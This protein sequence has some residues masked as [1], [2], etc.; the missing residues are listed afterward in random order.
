MA[1]R[2]QCPAG[3][4]LQPSNLPLPSFRIFLSAALSPSPS[5]PAPGQL[6]FAPVLMS[7][8]PPE[9]P[10]SSSEAAALGSSDSPARGPELTL[11]PPAEDE[12]MEEAEP[13]VFLS[14]MLSAFFTDPGRLVVHEGRVARAMVISRLSA[15]EL[16]VIGAETGYVEDQLLVPATEAY[17]PPSI[18]ELLTVA[19]DMTEILSWLGTRDVGAR[20][21]GTLTALGFLAR[22]VRDLEDDLSRY[23]GSDRAELMREV[24][25]QHVIEAELQT[26]LSE[27]DRA[28]KSQL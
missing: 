14:P 19:G 4:H 7:S 25:R 21:V 6:S 28:R 17:P 12:P 2:G 8:L 26:Q 20:L 11:T 1:V 22:R 10:P 27:A 13:T 16:E 3:L 18:V 23:V 5:H 9:N 15:S 24:A